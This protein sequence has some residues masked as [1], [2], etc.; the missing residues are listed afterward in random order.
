MC[1]VEPILSAAF[2]PPWRAK[3]TALSAISGLPW[4]KDIAGP[5]QGYSGG[6]AYGSI[7]EAPG[8]FAKQVVQGDADWALLNATD[9]LIELATGLPTTQTM[10]FFNGIMDVSDG[11][12]V[13]P[14]EF[15]MGR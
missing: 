7:T 3:E 11:E 6:G 4:V 8:R 12:D 13:A 14:I 1:A 10:R 15:L 2:P 5:L 9:D